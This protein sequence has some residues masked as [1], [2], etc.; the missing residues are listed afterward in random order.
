MEWKNLNIVMN[1]YTEF[2]QEAVKNHMPTYYELR[3]NIRFNL[4]VNDTV[5]EIEFEAP[6]YWKYANYGRRP[7]KFPPPD[8]IDRWIKRRKITPFPTRD[9]RTPTRKQLVFLISRK[10][11]EEGF[12]GSG[13]LEAGL[14]EQKGYWEDRIA[15]A[16]S[17]D[18]DLEI[19]SWLSPLMGPTVL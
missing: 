10:I 19:Y 4:K 15:R 1:A 8:A 18:I 7:G 13:F 17:D 9:G 12:K 5:F 6:E 2:V 11:A 16:I 14:E 3:D